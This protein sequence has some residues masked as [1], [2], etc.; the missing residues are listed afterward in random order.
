MTMMMMMTMMMIDDD[1]NAD[2]NDDDDID[3]TMHFIRRAFKA[4]VH[5]QS[6]KS[7]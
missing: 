6:S 3:G 7:N 1:N 4:V 5:C 2:D